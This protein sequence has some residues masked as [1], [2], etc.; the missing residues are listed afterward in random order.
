MQMDSRK[1]AHFVAVADH[2]GFTAAAK[3]VFVSQP[4]LSLAV[5]DFEAELGA[6]L[7]TRIGHR[8]P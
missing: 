4:A 7:F 5:K 8:V 6:Q 2:G 1:L 3:A